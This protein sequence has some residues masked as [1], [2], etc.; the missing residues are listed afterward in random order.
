MELLQLKYVCDAALTENFSVTARKFGVPPSD[1]SQSI[2]RLEQELSVHLF[3][4]Q[5]N[6]VKLNER[7]AEFCSRVSEALALIDGAVDLLNDD[8]NGGKLSICINISRRIVMQTLEQFKSQY[9]NVDV[10]TMHFTDPTVET[11]DLIVAT[12]DERLQ[13]YRKQKLFSEDLLL[14]IQGTS[15]YAKMDTVDIAL[16]KNEPFITMNDKSSLYRL[17][18][19]ICA[20]H[21][22]KPHLAMQSDDPYYIR[23]CV[24]MGLGVAI[25]PSVSWAG[26]FPEGVILKPL[27]GY[28]RDIYLYTDGKQYMPKCVKRFL[29]MLLAEHGEKE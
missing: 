20:D 22:F 6:R 18:Q 21:G 24:E 28:R 23:K 14:A 10:K 2:K 7:G 25:V 17:T 16:L 29:E 15:I 5:A 12:D 1:I 8:E 9:P 13:G 4:R 3:T 19:K 27:N 11:F 26:Q